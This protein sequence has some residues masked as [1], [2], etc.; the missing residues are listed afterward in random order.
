MGLLESNYKIAARSELERDI[1]RIEEK[2]KAAQTKADTKI[3]ANEIQNNIEFAQRLNLITQQQAEA[4]KRRVK[5]VVDFNELMKREIEDIPDDFENPHEREKR[6]Q[7]LDEL[8][9]QIRREKEQ[10]LSEGT[11]KY[12][13]RSQT[14]EERA[15]G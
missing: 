10:S 6:F 9:A 3:K 15:R 5:E 2:D 12:S 14:E 11:K 4:Y 13:V 7:S 8:Q 1:R